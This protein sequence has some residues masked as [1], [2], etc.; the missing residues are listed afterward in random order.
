[1][2]G[3]VIKNRKHRAVAN[4]Y[5]CIVSS[6][7]ACLTMFSCGTDS[8]ASNPGEVTRFVQFDASNILHGFIPTEGQFEGKVIPNNAFGLP[9]TFADGSSYRSTTLTTVIWVKSKT[10]YQTGLLKFTLPSEVKNWKL[11][12]TKLPEGVVCTP[13]STFIDFSTIAGTDEFVHE[14]DRVIKGNC[15][16]NVEAL[17]ETLPGDLVLDVNGTEVTIAASSAGE[18]P[19]QIPVS[20]FNS[21]EVTTWTPS[22]GAERPEYLT[23]HWD[24]IEKRSIEEDIAAISQVDSREKGYAITIKDPNSPCTIENGSAVM[25]TELHSYIKVKGDSQVVTPAL[26]KWH[27]D[28]RKQLKIVCS[29]PGVLASSAASAAFDNDS[30]KE[31]TFTITNSGQGEATL[32]TLTDTG[33]GLAAPFSKKSTSTCASGGKIAPNGTCTLIVVFSA[34][35]AGSYTD[36]LSIPY[37][38]GVETKTI[39]V[40]LTGTAIDVSLS[41]TTHDFGEFVVHN[42]AT[43]RLFTVKNLTTGA[44]TLGNLATREDLELAAPFQIYA[45]DTSACSSGQSLASGSSCTLNVGGYLSSSGTFNDTLVLTYTKSNSANGSVSATLK[46]VGKTP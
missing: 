11:E 3:S 5:T 44:I 16:Y 42:L 25:A 8:S 10:P 38:D 31:K 40:G 29:Q 9:T 32:G 15:V 14:G 22:S 37:N 2:G 41:P 30:N 17:A 43:K 4:V 35:A 26:R 21:S 1:M 39:S 13:S 36:T 33:L 34:T 6:A 24:E 7:I 46:V 18:T 19:F 45:G 20:T 12:L 27:S 28:A 23:E